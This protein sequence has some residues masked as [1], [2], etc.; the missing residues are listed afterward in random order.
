MLLGPGLYLTL[1]LY[2]CIRSN[3]LSMRAQGFD[4]GP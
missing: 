3:H 2:G 1:N 4:L